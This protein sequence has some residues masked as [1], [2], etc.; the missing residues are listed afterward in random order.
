MS[1]FFTIFKNKKY[2]FKKFSHS[3]FHAWT[4]SRLHLKEFIL[5]G[6]GESS[7]H[8]WKG[9]IDSPSRRNVAE[10]LAGE[11]K[12]YLNVSHMAVKLP[13]WCEQNSPLL[14]MKRLPV[15]SF[16]RPW[17]SRLVTKLIW[18]YLLL[19]PQLY[20]SLSSPL[21]LSFYFSL[22]VTT[23]HVRVCKRQSMIS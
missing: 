2:I 13:A 14:I 11:V 7:F 6:S 12:S 21:S 4:E 1:S 9:W 3:P 23:V 15:P 17:C 19:C 20:L 18:S 22:K 10:L 8:S 5:I 16:C